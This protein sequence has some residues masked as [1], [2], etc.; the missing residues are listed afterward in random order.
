MFDEQLNVWE[1]CVIMIL[2][3]TL[4]LLG[5]EVGVK[6]IWGVIRF[7]S[8]GTFVVGIIGVIQGCTA[9][10]GAVLAALLVL[11][12]FCTGPLDEQAT[13]SPVSIVIDTFKD[14]LN[15]S[16][17]CPSAGG[18]G[19][20]TDINNVIFGSRDTT[21]SPATGTGTRI[22]ILNDNVLKF[23]LTGTCSGGI[24]TTYPKTGLGTP[25]DVSG[26]KRILLPIKFLSGTVDITIELNDGTTSHD[27]M[28]SVSTL[29]NVIFQLSDY[30]SNGVDLTNLRQIIFTVAGTGPLEVRFGRPFG[31]AP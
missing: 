10:E 22:T 14:G 30:D 20:S 3:C 25:A 27:E 23:E 8:V 15:S 26:S 2:K 9:K 18:G 28:Q 12:G 21:N 5:Q 7:G 1:K 4:S 16:G 24:V 19:A 31:F 6:R 11:L 17:G 13:P 29:S